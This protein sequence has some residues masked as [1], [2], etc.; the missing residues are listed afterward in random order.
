MGVIVEFMTLLPPTDH[1]QPQEPGMLVSSLS[2][3]SLAVGE[4]FTAMETTALAP[5]IG[6]GRDRYRS[7]VL[8]LSLQNVLM[9][10]VQP[11]AAGPSEVLLGAFDALEAAI[12]EAQWRQEDLLVRL[13]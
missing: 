1:G 3:N 10:Q 12:D 6:D 9:T 5:L 11:W 8:T 7:M 2:V 4:L 13:S